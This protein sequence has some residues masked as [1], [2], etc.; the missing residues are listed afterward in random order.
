M[1]QV[2]KANI[3]GDTNLSQNGVHAFVVMRSEV[4]R[5]SRSVIGCVFV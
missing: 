5:V 2:A 1:R 3:L 4:E